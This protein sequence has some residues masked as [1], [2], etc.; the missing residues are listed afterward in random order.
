[1]DP[2]AEYERRLSVDERELVRGKRRDVGYSLAR[3]FVFLIAVVVS[4]FAF[5]QPSLS[6]WLILP[7]SVVFVALLGL[8]AQCRR[9]LEQSRRR[10]A[11]YQTSLARLRDEWA[12]RGEQGTHYAPEGHLYA[13][14]LDLFGRGSLFELICGAG[15]AVGRHRLA[16]WLMAGAG[17]NEILARQEAVQELSLRLDLREDLALRG[18]ELDATLAPDALRQWADS[19]APLANVRV[20]LLAGAISGLTGLAIAGWYLAGTGLAP[21]TFL[22]LAQLLVMWRVREPVSAVVRAASDAAAELRVLARLL[23]RL[24]AEDFDDEMLKRLKRE[25]EFE[26]LPPSKQVAK[27]VRRVDLLDQLTHNQLLMIVGLVFLGVPQTAMAIEAWRARVGPSINAWLSAVAD[28]EALASLARFAYENPGYAFPE[29]V[30]GG[31]RFESEGMAHPMLPAA[32][33]VSNDVELGLEKRLLLVSGSNMSGKSTLLRAVGVNAVLALS[34]APVCARRMRIS[35]LRIGASIR[36][37]DSLLRGNSRFYAEISK[38]R[39]IVGEAGE[40]LPLLF[41]MDEIFGGTNSNDRRIGAAAVIRT[42]I[43]HGAVGLVTTHDLA[44]SA[45]AEEPA[46]KA[47]NVHFEDDYRDGKIFF[48]YHLKP[49]MLERGNALALM[50]SIGLEV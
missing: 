14:D 21:F 16:K 9:K 32:T 40:A 7:P 12:G 49:G 26:G 33:R 41:L 10:A 48:D 50:R 43:E 38:I 37:Q 20:R 15:T 47:V 29:V 42:L 35:P 24:E 8:H 18:V 36:V 19:P 27:L 1:M 6:L 3:F 22:I 13:E 11:Y 23:E 17:R 4:V 34:G 30:E 44:L 31:A 45:I 46:L 28:F 39:G 25:I 5:S 2:K